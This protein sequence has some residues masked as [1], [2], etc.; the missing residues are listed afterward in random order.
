V[1]VTIDKG[2]LIPFNPDD[3]EMK[4]KI[5]K[6]SRAQSVMQPRQATI[7]KDQAVNH[8]RRPAQEGGLACVRNGPKKGA[9]QGDP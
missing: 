2:E 5:A 1:K 7:A 3:Q 4:M 6:R 9:E 8:R